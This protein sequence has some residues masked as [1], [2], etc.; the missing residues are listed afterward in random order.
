MNKLSS[1]LSLIRFQNL[2]IIALT[3]VFIKFSLVNSYLNNSAL[4][5]FDFSIYLFALITIVSS[6]YII[7][8]IYD[9]EIDKIN[10]PKTRIIEQEISIK[11]AIKMYY[12]LNLVGVFSGF[13]AALK[14]NRW[15]FG[16]IFIFF[17]FSLW[18]YSKNNKT[19]FVIG[20]MQVAFLTAL[21]I[22]CLA[23]FDLSHMKITNEN[24]SKIILYIII[25]Y[26]GFSFI[27]TLIREIVKDLEDLEGDKK[28]GANTLA[29]NYSLKKTKK[30]TSALIL[31]AILGIAYFQYFQYSVMSS[32]FSIELSYWGSD[33]IAV[34]YTSLLQ[35]LL[36]ILLTKIRTSNTKADFHYLST[37]CKVI[38]L[39]G[40]SSI[41][42]FTFLHLN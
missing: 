37:L 31:T 23:I 9:V 25:C 29:I 14:V 21:S 5:A 40:I 16:F 1:F 39:F 19:S 28:I 27:T 18:R 10:K 41:P 22:I 15:W 38:M 33:L 26:S 3:Q 12:A 30:I 32:T 4:S 7:N 35:I 17:A 34:I 36:I 20:N 24:G 2:L 42:I 6:G 13:Y 8:D 11:T